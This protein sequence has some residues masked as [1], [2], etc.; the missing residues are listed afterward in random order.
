MAELSPED[1]MRVLIARC[2]RKI[3]EQLDNNDDLKTSG[4]LLGQLANEKTFLFSL[5]AMLKIRA[6]QEKSK[7]KENREAAENMAMR[8]DV[9]ELVLDMVKGQYDAVSRMC[10]VYRMRIDELRMSGML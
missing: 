10:T 3:P 9:A 6:R 5:L 2:Y 7:G 8:R 4:E 1:L